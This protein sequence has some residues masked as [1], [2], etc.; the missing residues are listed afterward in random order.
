MSAICCWLRCFHLREILTQPLKINGRQKTAMAVSDQSIVESK[1]R[2]GCPNLLKIMNGTGMTPKRTVRRVFLSSDES[3]QGLDES[4][5]SSPVQLY[6]IHNYD[7]FFIKKPQITTKDE[8]KY[9]TC[10]TGY[11]SSAWTIAKLKLQCPPSKRV[12]V[13][14]N[15]SSSSSGE[16]IS[17]GMNLIIKRVFTSVKCTS[18]KSFPLIHKYQI[19]SIFTTWITYRT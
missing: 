17:M 18:S 13:M 5:C 15:A 4:C 16:R 8:L 14:S 2:R 12:Y 10:E 7:H 11:F 6:S 19:F 9:A 1:R 3:L